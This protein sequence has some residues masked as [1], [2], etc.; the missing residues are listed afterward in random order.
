MRPRFG[1][2]SGGHSGDYGIGFTSP[3]NLAMLP[4]QNLKIDQQ[5]IPRS[6]NDGGCSEII[7]AIIALEKKIPIE[8]VTEGVENEVLQEHL[9]RWGCDYQ[10]GFH[11]CHPLSLEEV[12]KFLGPQ[13]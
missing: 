13:K 2:V 8:V 7:Q 4:I 6:Q 11:I 12:M 5:L 3:V 9:M 10:Q 1:A